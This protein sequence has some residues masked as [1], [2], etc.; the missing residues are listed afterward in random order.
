MPSLREAYLRLKFE[1]ERGN[2]D[3]KVHVTFVEREQ[4]ERIKNDKRIT[5]FVLETKDADACSELHAEYDRILR[6]VHNK[7]VALSL[8]VRAW[9]DALA[10]SELDKLMAVMDAEQFMEKPR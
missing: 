6:R 5:K 10:D 8:L 4:A 3:E 1:L 7:S 2:G 9:R